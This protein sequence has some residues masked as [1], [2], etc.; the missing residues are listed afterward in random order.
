[1]NR[2]AKFNSISYYIYKDIIKDMI[3]YIREYYKRKFHL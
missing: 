2:K 1:M 3:C